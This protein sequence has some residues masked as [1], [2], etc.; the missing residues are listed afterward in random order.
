MIPSLERAVGDERAR[1]TQLQTEAR[2]LQSDCSR[3][4][5]ELKERE[6]R[7]DEQRRLL[8]ELEAKFREA[9]QSLAAD[10]LKRN[11]QAFLDLAKTAMSEFQQGARADLEGRQK[12]IAEVVAPVR[13]PSTST[14]PRY[15]A[16]R[17]TGS[18]PT[19]P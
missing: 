10:A 3:L 2:N 12:A 18:R 16:S 14:T 11:N 1:V 5:A 19:R 8:E 15:R 6:D 7:L 13:R 17:A 4:K 9:F